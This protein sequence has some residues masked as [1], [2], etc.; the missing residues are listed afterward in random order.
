MNKTSTLYDLL[1]VR[2]DASM[3]EIKLAYR[4]LVRQ[5]HPD[6]HAGHPAAQETLKTINIAAETLC[7]PVA[8]ARY[9]TLLQQTTA[10]RGARDI[11][12]DG[13]DVAYTVTI[14]AAEAHAGT[15]RTLRFHGP[16]GCPREV[17]VV[18]Q[19][20]AHAGQRITLHGAGGPGQDGTRH[21]DLHVV[22]HVAHG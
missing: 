9:D 19:P 6:L 18:I 8:R 17:G 10:R 20:G 3:R 15:Y 21:G 12:R 16:D 7:D 13:Y 2:R 1:G 5:Y 14:S 22:V 11:R 4:Q